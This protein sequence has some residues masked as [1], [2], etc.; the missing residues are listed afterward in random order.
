M[1]EAEAET[2]DSTSEETEA[3]E[4]STDASES[5]SSESTETTETTESTAREST[6]YDP[7]A[8]VD[9]SGAPCILDRTICLPASQVNITLDLTAAVDKAF[10]LGREPEGTTEL[11]EGRLDVDLRDLVTMDEAYIREVLERAYEE[12]LLEGAETTVEKGKTTVK[13]EKDEEIEVDCLTITFGTLSRKLDTEA[14]FTQIMDGYFS[15][16]FDQ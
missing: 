8:P 10:A 11:P 2:Q 4:E 9:E 15:E 3:T 16:D 12:T 14:L 1:N 7:D 6:D 5:A 13:N